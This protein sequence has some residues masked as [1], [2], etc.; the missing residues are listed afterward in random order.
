LIKDPNLTTGTVFDAS[1][2]NKLMLS[3]N[4]KP[5]G[6]VERVLDEPSGTVNLTID[7]RGCR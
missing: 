5:E 4:L 2:F 3:K 1:V 7:L 6:D